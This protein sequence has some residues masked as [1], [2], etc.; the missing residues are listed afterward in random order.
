MTDS[1]NMQDERDWTLVATQSRRS[2]PL[3]REVPLHNKYETMGLERGRTV[4]VMVQT[5][6]GTTTLSWSNQ[7]PR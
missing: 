6:K 3:T 5:W 7:G 1:K 4:W 2:L